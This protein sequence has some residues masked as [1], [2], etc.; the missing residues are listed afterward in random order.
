LLDS[1][2][3]KKSPTAT[4]ADDDGIE[5]HQIGDHGEVVAARTAHTKLVAAASC[6][7][8]SPQSFAIS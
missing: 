2:I 4:T 1:R 8:S 6:A 7:V 3:L 5:H